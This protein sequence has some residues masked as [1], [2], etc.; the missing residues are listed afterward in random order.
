[1]TIFKD[2]ITNHMI[3]VPLIS[4][5][6]SQIVKTVVSIISE[7]KFVWKKILSDGGMPSAHVATVMSLAVMCGWTHGYDSA[8]F[9]IAVVSA[10]VIL[11]DSVGARFQTGANARA[12]KRLEEQLNEQLPEGSR[13]DAGKLKL[14]GG[15]TTIQCIAGIAVGIVVAVLYIVIVPVS[16]IVY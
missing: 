15:H 13:V 4:W 1:M 8:I 7:K 12:I 14:V 11:R 6:V 16:S 10:V 3:L 5:A 9:A 2:I